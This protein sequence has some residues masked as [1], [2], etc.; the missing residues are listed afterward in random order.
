MVYR[1][2]WPVATHQIGKKWRRK[3]TLH[4][5]RFHCAK[6]KNTEKKAKQWKLIKNQLAAFAVSAW[7]DDECWEICRYTPVFFSGQFVGWFFGLFSFCHS[8][9]LFRIYSWH[10]YCVLLW[11]ISWEQTDETSMKL[12][13]SETFSSSDST[14]N[15]INY[16]F[17][18]N[19]FP[20]FSSSIST[21]FSFT[22]KHTLC[23]ALVYVDKKNCIFLC[24]LA[25]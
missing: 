7:C 23:S 4:I 2:R 3:N 5:F 25:N 21:L 12:V 16:K 19:F 15:G 20:F 22:H 18:H 14:Q 24:R 1:R 11:G 10:C 9:L 6:I 8:H 17:S 13:D